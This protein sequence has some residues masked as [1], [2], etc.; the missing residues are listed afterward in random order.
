MAMAS[1]KEKA[2]DLTQ[3]RVYVLPT[4]LVDRILEFQHAMGLTSEVEAARRLL[5]E[6]LK[7][8][9]TYK[10]LLGRLQSKLKEVRFLSDAATILLGHPQVT[11]MKFDK[12]KDAMNFTLTNGLE[13]R[14]E[15]NGNWAVWDE[16]ESLVEQFPPK[17]SASF[18][19]SKT[20][21]LDDDIPF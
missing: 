16:Q 6:A 20:S 18:G 2:K 19:R 15:A 9:D 12:E 10:T 8:R 1:D 21:H 13:A 3:R 14:I 7:S 5:D 11:G 4:E 17:Q